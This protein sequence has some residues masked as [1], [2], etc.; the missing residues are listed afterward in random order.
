MKREIRKILSY[1]TRVLMIATFLAIIVPV[2]TYAAD[3]DG[4]WIQV[5]NMT[6]SHV[7]GSGI[8]TLDNGKVLVTTGAT[9][10]ASANIATSSSELFDPLSRTW[11]T[12]GSVN[13]VR[14]LSGNAIVKLNDG[15]V[16]IAGNE[17][18]GVS[19]LSSVELY[20]PS[21]GTW[22]YTGS[23]QKARRHPA[24][25]KLQNGKVL[26]TAGANGIPDDNRYL[27][28]TEI[29]DPT[30]KQWTYSGNLNVAREGA[31]KIILL[32]NGKVLLAGGYTQQ[33]KLIDR[34]E[35]YDPNSRVWTISQMP[36]AWGAA[37]MT[38]LNNGKVLVS[39]GSIGQYTYTAT[40]TNK[41]LLYDQDTNT[42][43]PTG[44]MHIARAGHN[45]VLM[46]DGKVLVIGGGT[47]STEI[48]D[49]ATGQWTIAAETHQ[50][51][52]NGIA[53]LQNG[54][55]LAIGGDPDGVAT[56]LYTNRVLP[57]ITVISPN[58]GEL[59]YTGD[60]Y[61]IKWSYTGN[62][63]DKVKIDLLKNEKLIKNIASKYSIGKNG[64]GT[65]NWVVPSQV[66]GVDYKIR[67]TSTTNSAYTDIS[68]NNFDLSIFD[69]YAGYAVSGNVT[70]PQSYK[71][72]QGKWKEPKVYCDNSLDGTQESIWIGLGGVGNV[73]K[74]IAQI[75]TIA[76]C[77]DGIPPI[78]SRWPVFE[79]FN[80][81]K[82]HGF[83]VI[84]IAYK[85]FTNF[86]VLANVYAGDDIYAEVK[87]IGNDKYSLYLH[88][89]TKG[90]HTKISPQKFIG[91]YERYSA[92]W[93]VEKPPEHLLAK[94]DPITFKN[95]KVDEKSIT[96]WSLVHQYT[97][98]N[99]EDH[100]IRA[101]TGSLDK[102]GSS[103]SVKWRHE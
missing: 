45:A 55:V 39:G 6:N 89:I 65:Y 56:E 75:G 53:V 58:G 73:R 10:P 101:E 31:P 20:D 82:S 17:G 50:T 62:P 72:V 34:A 80:V 44:S 96:N 70:K 68:D 61:V 63:G 38:V 24:V 1:I 102:T 9:T 100:I 88:D 37:T 25:I 28:S 22:S 51:W 94:F 43:T 87:Y 26:I 19:D 76:Q 4:V 64:I 93:I 5:P 103:F 49:P 84:R 74:T 18:P 90:W 29:Y 40:V 99:K 60:T 14:W 30:T 32:K 57:T 95:A 77:Y 2:T 42:W 11:T 67:I 46:A 47:K 23:L 13:Q 79:M 27:S 12:T 83:T 54:Y 21:T 16:M 78:V 98:V 36:Y 81:G 3:S 15:K 59:L 97:M 71:Y 7:W 86:P 35:I 66:S 48:Y 92:G 91:K 8:I 41:A 85:D 33:D 69:N 52:H